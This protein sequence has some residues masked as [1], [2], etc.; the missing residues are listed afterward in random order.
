MTKTKR[1]CICLLLKYLLQRHLAVTN[2][3]FS[4]WK[5]ISVAIF[6]ALGRLGTFWQWLTCL[7]FCPPR[8]QKQNLPI[9][10]RTEHVLIM[11]GLWTYIFSI[12]F[13]LKFFFSK[14]LIY[15][16]TNFVKSVHISCFPSSS[17]TKFSSFLRKGSRT[18]KRKRG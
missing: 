8:D 14:R 6:T 17:L 12:N 11:I 10:N 16:L 18:N 4:W 15:T 1:L 3:T 5:Y 7:G 9:Q 2:P 13:N